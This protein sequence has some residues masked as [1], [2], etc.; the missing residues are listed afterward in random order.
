MQERDMICNNLTVEGNDLLF[1]G[2]PVRA[3]AE[4]YGTPLYLFDEDKVR[5]NCR[6]YLTALREEFGENCRALYASKAAAFRALYRVMKEEGMGI[7]VVSSGEIA[8][9][10]SA[11]YPLQNAFFHSNNK[12]DADVRY[13][14]HRGVGYFVA[15][16]EEELYAIN[17]IAGE[18]G[19]K[20]KALL[21]VT[22]GI[23]PHTYAEV[24]TGKVDSKFGSPIET[25]AA[26]RV[27]EI[28][29]SLPNVEFVGYHCH[30]G[31]QVFDSD[32][33]LQTVEIMFA[34]MAQMRD[35]LGY[36]ASVMD[37]GGGY[38]VRYTAADPHI[39]I[40]ANIHTVA[41]AIKAK[42]Q[43]LGLPLPVICMEPGR[44]IVAN[45]GL[46]A[47]T[48]GTRKVIEGYKTY[49]SVDGGMAD[50][51]RYALYRSA[52]TVLPATRMNEEFSATYSVV[53][54]CCESG[55]ILQENVSLPQSMGRGDILAVLTTGAYNYSMA[56][57]YNRLPKPPVVMIANGEDRLAVR[58]ESLEDLFRLDE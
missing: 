39:D 2:V 50:N 13:A 8:T 23:D 25:G 46:T 56:S 26:K 24:A 34:F 10:Y 45:A 28:A 18:L 21:R 11:E 29:V 3:M 58:R 38:G 12:T 31:S 7:D 44:S 35:E 49:I 16:N 41:S 53:G 14:I 20:Q 47:Y 1:A 48:V 33:Y 37:L 19:V 51:P 22:P 54:R 42:C 52:Y 15:D 4:K 17:R 32:V 55:D 40:A 5:C 9:A 30:V 57:N 36:T 6:T 27:V 43:A